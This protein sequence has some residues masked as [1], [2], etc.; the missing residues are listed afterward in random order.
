VIADLTV[1][2]WSASVNFVAAA[3]PSPT[4]KTPSADSVTPGPW[5]F[6]ITFLVAVAVVFLIIDMT[7]RTRR[8]RY[9]AE[10]AA[11]LDAEE[12]EAK[13]RADGA[14]SD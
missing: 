9:R 13:K 6:A 14:A 2:L 5:G 11:K 1:R 10:I 8:V 4:P 12:A 7:R 3:T